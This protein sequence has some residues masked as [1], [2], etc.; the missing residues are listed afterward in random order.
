MWHALLL[1]INDLPTYKLTPFSS[2]LLRNIQDQEGPKVIPEETE[3]NSSKTTVAGGTE[4]L[5]PKAAS[6]SVQ[7]DAN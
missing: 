6:V 1:N 7:E 3:I 4:E 5:A 2:I